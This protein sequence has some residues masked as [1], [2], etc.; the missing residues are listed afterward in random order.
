[1]I[2]EKIQKQLVKWLQ[3]KR[4]AFSVGLEGAKRHPAEQA[5]MKAMGMQS[6]HPDITLYLPHGKTIFIELKTLKGRVSDNQKERHE[7]LKKLG[8]DVHV[9]KA[10]DGGVAIDIVQA[11]LTAASTQTSNTYEKNEA[12][13]RIH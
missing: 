6:G 1:M 7:T 3:A 4:V 12:V 9:L 5:R 10:E 2:E 13:T 8:F 11:I